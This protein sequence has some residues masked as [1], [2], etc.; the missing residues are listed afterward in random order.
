M[1]KE[2]ECKTTLRCDCGEKAAA[3]DACLCGEVMKAE[4]AAEVRESFR[5]CVAIAMKAI[6]DAEEEAPK[7]AAG[8]CLANCLRSKAC[9]GQR[10]RQR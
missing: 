6:R 5:K 1:R 9:H 8:C 2:T 3:P 10:I 4:R 7:L